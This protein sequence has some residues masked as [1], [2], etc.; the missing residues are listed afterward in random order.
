MRMETT[1][2]KEYV[3][4]E[5]AADVLKLADRARESLIEYLD[6]EQPERPE[7]LENIKPLANPLSL[8]SEMYPLAAVWGKEDPRLFQRLLKAFWA[9]AGDQMAYLLSYLVGRQFY[10]DASWETKLCCGVTLDE[11]IAPAARAAVL[12]HFT[13]PEYHWVALDELERIACEEPELLMEAQSLWLRRNVKG[14]PVLGALYLR[15]APEG[16]HAGQMRSIFIDM[17]NM[18]LREA[19]K[20]AC[21]PGQLSDLER[22]LR[23]DG[24]QILSEKVISAFSHANGVARALDYSSQE[25]P[26][27][28]LLLGRLPAAEMFLTLCLQCNPAQ[29]FRTCLQSAAPEEAKEAL[30]WLAGR[31]S[32]KKLFSQRGMM[33]FLHTR[34]LSQEEQHA[35]YV[36]LLRRL[37]ARDPKGVQD[38]VT[39]QLLA[40]E[41]QTL[42]LFREAVPGLVKVAMEESVQSLHSRVTD[43]LLN[44]FADPSEKSLVKRFLSGQ[45]S[46]EDFLK[47]RSSSGNIWFNSPVLCSY[48]SSYED[49]FADRCL[50]V[51]LFGHFHIAMKSWLN[52]GDMVKSAGEFLT[53]ALHTGLSM[54]QAVEALEIAV[55][56]L[57]DEIKRLDCMQG[58]E[59]YLIAHHDTFAAELPRIAREGSVFG[60]S[61]AVNAMAAFPQEYREDLLACAGETSK[62]V[63]KLLRAIY[64]KHRDWEDGVKALLLSKKAAEREMALEVIGEWGAEPFA[65]EL[66]AMLAKEKSQKLAIQCQGLLG[67]VE[68]KGAG[69]APATPEEQAAAMLKGGKAR[70]IQWLF[71][72]PFLPVRRKDGTQAEESLLQALLICC[73]ESWEHDPVQACALLVNE[74]HPGDLAV[75]AC[76]VLDRWIQQG[77]QSKQKWVLT[78]AS[79]YG[80]GEAVAM[81]KRQV[82]EWPQNAR[83]AIACEAVHALVMSPVPEALLT[84]DSISRKFKFR[85]VKAAAGQAMQE[86]AKKLGI[87]QEEL[88]DRI[89][90]DLGFGSDLSRT[91]D[92]GTRS[93]TVSLPPSLEMEVTCGDKRLKTMPSPG[94][95]DD[96]AKA[97]EAFAAFKALKKQLKTTVDAQKLR[98]ELALSVNRQ[99]SADN[100]EKLFVKNPIMHQFAISLI[101][102]VYEGN[103]LKETFRYMEDGSFNTR[104]EEEYTLPGEGRI[105]L[106]HPI[107]LSPEELE[108]WKQQL[109]DYEVEQSIEQLSRP[110]FRVTEAEIGHKSLERFGG[111]MLS[112]LSLMGKLMGMGWYRGSVQDAGGFYDFYR[113]DGE[114]GVD[115]SFSGSFVGDPSETVTLYDAVFYRAGTVARGS[116]VYDEPTGENIF[117]LDEVDPRYFSEIVYQ[118]QKA[119]ASSEERDMDW[120][121]NR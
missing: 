24:P 51:C 6:L 15:Y 72:S 75:F 38:T 42:N 17:L 16:P 107:E 25:L 21:T 105:G 26:C 30:P 59:N 23:G 49:E 71:S 10:G 53:R 90:P 73:S 69:A 34:Y 61:A 99:W 114:I 121:K 54:P 37:K 28:F 45:Q 89:V 86:A 63:R 14:S 74:L 67:V 119:S 112:C 22:Y 43:S 82:A 3:L 57:Y 98:L 60:R 1:S 87:S 91:F 78:F 93:F 18:T 108:G 40:G 56:S 94:K 39:Q 77:A 68:E 33:N 19:G 27:C 29:T 96:P 81:I 79:L 41:V 85:Q 104:E 44:A 9:L 106:V 88:A 46:M 48:L 47:T 100:W 111:L 117:L 32:V 113:E 36:D 20:I 13:G 118:L 120:K 97:E 50:A 80:G 95:N 5:R 35:L 84:V 116:Y 55:E 110:I 83:G 52:G 2:P 109:E 31:I 66:T 101:W 92:Y 70:K 102:G 64:G 103:K 7:L 62:Q 76:E 65:K 11:L 8:Q 12:A 115:L 58:T 4:A